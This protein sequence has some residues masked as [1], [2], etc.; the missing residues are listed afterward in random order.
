MATSGPYTQSVWFKTTT[1]VGGGIMG[2]SNVA[3]GAGSGENR[4]IW[5]DNDGKVAFGIRRGT[6]GNPTNTFVRS[7]ATYNDGKWHQAV[8]T[9]DGSRISL[10]MDGVLNETLGV[11]NV[12]DTGAGVPPGRATSTWR[13][14]TP[15][16]ARTSTARRCRCPTSSAAA[17]TRLRSTRS[18]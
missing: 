17:S 1:N 18:R 2:F 11:T 14:S 12:V 6:V 16:S 5:M 3:T 15:C 8:A 13:T 4:A 7:T 9:F 10:Y